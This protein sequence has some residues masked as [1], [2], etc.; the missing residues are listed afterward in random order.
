L[1]AAVMAKLSKSLLFSATDSAMKV[2]PAVARTEVDINHLR[3]WQVKVG[4]YREKSSLVER[5][6]KFK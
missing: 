6:S 4:Y 3:D 1:I 2:E 5:L